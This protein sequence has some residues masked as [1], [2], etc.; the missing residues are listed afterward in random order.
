MSEGN[1]YFIVSPVPRAL[2]IGFTRGNP[3]KR[4]KQLQTGSPTELVLLG[5]Y[6]GSLQEEQQLHREMQHLRVSG[7][8]F[9]LDPTANEILRGPFICMKINNH[10]TGHA[11]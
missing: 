10:L 5:W 11:A 7:E 6:P 2:K 4:L 1:V 8:W 9:R 3:N